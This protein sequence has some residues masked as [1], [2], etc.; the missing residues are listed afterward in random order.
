MNKFWEWMKSKYHIEKAF[1]DKIY[2]VSYNVL[3]I[4]YMEEYLMIFHRCSLAPDS[5]IFSDLRKG[6]NYGELRYCQL[7]KEI[8][9]LDKE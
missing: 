1:V 6:R 2:G 8:K 9:K 5:N 4:G 7:L 3:L